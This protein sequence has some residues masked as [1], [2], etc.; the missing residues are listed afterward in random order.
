MIERDALSRMNHPGIVKLYWTYKDNRSLCKGFILCELLSIFD[1]ISFLFVLDFVL[2]LARNGELYTYIRRVN[3]KQ[4]RKIEPSLLNIFFF[5]FFF[6][7][8]GAI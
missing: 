4:K 6:L 7:L 2:D 5:F 8:V 1:L 3:R